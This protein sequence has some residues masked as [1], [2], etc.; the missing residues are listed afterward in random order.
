MKDHCTWF[1]ERW[2]VWVK[3]YKWKIVDISDC[4]KLH[5]E[6]CSTG[7][8]AR[9]LREKKAVGSLLITLGGA[10]GCWVQYPRRMF[11]RV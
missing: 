5:D 8:F 2:A 11:K 9:C 1:P 10:I 3:W 4:C 6:K 7:S